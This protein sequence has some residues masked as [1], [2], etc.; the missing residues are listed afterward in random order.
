MKEQT[1]SRSQVLPDS[2]VNTTNQTIPQKS[3]NMQQSSYLNTYVVGNSEEEGGRLSKKLAMMVVVTGCHC[4]SVIM[5]IMTKKENLK[6]TLQ[7]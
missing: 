6:S 5:M 2:Q 3:N 1:M 4:Q 7:Q